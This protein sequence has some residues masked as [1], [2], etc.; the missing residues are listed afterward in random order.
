MISHLKRF[1]ILLC[2][3]IRS[4]YKTNQASLLEEMLINLQAAW[5]K[6]MTVELFVLFYYSNFFLEHFGNFLFLR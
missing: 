5:L 2:N 4:I 1:V 6:H 3:F